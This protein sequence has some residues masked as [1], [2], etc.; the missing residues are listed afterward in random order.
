MRVAKYR[1]RLP[2]SI[3]ISLSGAAGSPNF[4]ENTRACCPSGCKYCWSGSELVWAKVLAPLATWTLLYSTAQI[5]T[6]SAFS[7]V[8]MVTS[9]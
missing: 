4:V 8:R 9:T 6:E 5:P 7:G 3:V 2:A 1:I